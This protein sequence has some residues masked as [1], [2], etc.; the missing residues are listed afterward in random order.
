MIQ[1]F[2]EQQKEIAI[3]GEKA[4]E[5]GTKI[6]QNYFPNAIIAGSKNVSKLP[7]LENRFVENETL[8]YLCQNRTC[9][10]PTDNLEEILIELKLQ[11]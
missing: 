6:N 8:L 9:Q 2:S 5:N 11:S 4:S 10:K 3:C 7:F 1:N